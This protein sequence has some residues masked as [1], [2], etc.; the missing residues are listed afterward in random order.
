M[1]QEVS[2]I[3]QYNQNEGQNIIDLNRQ[4]PERLVVGAQDPL[5]TKLWEG[6]TGNTYQSTINEFGGPTSYDQ[7]TADA[8]GLDQSGAGKGAHDVAK[9]V[10]S[11]FG[12]PAALGGIGEGFDAASGAFSGA[13][14][15]ADVSASGMD[16]GGAGVETPAMPPAVLDSGPV[17]PAAQA[18][19]PEA[20]RAQ[21]LIETA[22]GAW[23]QGG[24]VPP[25]AA[26]A[27]PA[28]PAAPSPT[29]V[30]PGSAPLQPAGAGGTAPSTDSQ[31]AA[32]AT[33]PLAPPAPAPAPAP[34]VT[35]LPASGGDSTSLG[36]DPLTTGQ[37]P[38]TAQPSQD[39]N[40]VERALRSIGVWD[41]AKG[42][43]GKNA[44][45]LGLMIGGQVAQNRRGDQLSKDLRAIS[46]GPK[47]ASDQLLA[48]GT[49][50]NVPPAVMQQYDQSYKDKVSE[51]NQRYANMGRDP[52]TDT[53][54]QAEIQ[55]AKDAKDAQVANYA[56]GL[57]TQG[58][59][60]AQVAAGPQTQAA[61][62]GAQKD[63][64]L[65]AAMANGLQTLA[66]MQAYQG[67]QATP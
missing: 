17:M 7:Q 23:S 56:S 36:T 58:L 51:I 49:S 31:A 20:L 4:D 35:S 37:A 62:A 27:A 10:A 65:Q 29:G 19:S 47:A 46:A 1:G 61:I 11:Y 48:E 64:A 15:G 28:T 45:P 54:A 25:P 14:S 22:P 6:L 30:D 66:M 21:G 18:E 9:V 55:K 5:S 67:K 44:L 34:A 3:S 2:D 60:A 43:V 16:F 33:A 12:T 32:P 39:P 57:T 41:P 8:R 50:G 59:Q 42:A 40:M 52:R 38:A 13:G 24:G 26:S 53:G 63:E